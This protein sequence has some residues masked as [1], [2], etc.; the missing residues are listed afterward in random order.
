[1]TD[2]KIPSGPPPAKNIFQILKLASVFRGNTIEVFR[3]FQTQYGDTYVLQFGETRGFIT[4]HPDLMHEVLVTKAA[5]F[6]KDRDI[7]N[8]KVGLARFLGNGLLTSDGEFW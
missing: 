4:S 2:Y 8:S 3:N 5:S 6:H 1:M 7:K